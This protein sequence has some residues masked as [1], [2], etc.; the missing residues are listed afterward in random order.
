MILDFSIGLNFAEFSKAIRLGSL[1]APPYTILLR[2][3]LSAL[4]A[5][6]ACALR[7]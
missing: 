3:P 2:L 5:M 1:K 4:T 7:E 6:P